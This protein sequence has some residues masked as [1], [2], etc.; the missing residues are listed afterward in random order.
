MA[1]KGDDIDEAQC[2]FSLVFTKKP[3]RKDD[4]LKN[5]DANILL[6][7]EPLTGVV[8]V[9]LDVDGRK[10]FPTLSLELLPTKLHIECP[11]ELREILDGKAKV[12]T[13]CSTD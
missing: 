11:A 1:S 9:L 7:G 3:G 2:E 12:R 4:K 8:R 6:N 10:H 13:V 5:Y